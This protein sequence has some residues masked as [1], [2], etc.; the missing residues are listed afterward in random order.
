MLPFVLL[1]VLFKNTINCLDYIVSVIDEWMNAYGALVEW[2]WEGETEENLSQCHFVHH[3]SQ[4]DW[5]VNEHGLAQWQAGD[6]PPDSW[7]C[8]L[9]LCDCHFTQ[10]Y[11][12]HS[13]MHSVVCCTVGPHP[14]PKRVLHRVQSSASTFNFQYPHVSLR[15]SS[16]C[17][18]LLPRILV[19]SILP[20][21]PCF[22]MQFLCTMWPIQLAFRL[23]ILCRIFL[24]SL[25]LCNTLSFCPPLSSTRFRNFLSIISPLYWQIF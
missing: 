25:T 11:P 17:L 7:H 21:I 10:R 22:R 2:C 23:F 18:R 9:S 20:P 19:T 15:S 4:M 8:L 1:N 12:T 6:W 16:S 13:F 14:L 5:P 3:K 24:P